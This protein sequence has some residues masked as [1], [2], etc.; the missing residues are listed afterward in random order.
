M[1]TDAEFV[2]RDRNAARIVAIEQEARSAAATWQRRDDHEAHPA[3]LPDSLLYDPLSGDGDFRCL[4]LADRVERVGENGR[5]RGFGEGY[6]AG[7]SAADREIAALKEGLT[8]LLDV[9]EG[10]ITGNAVDRARALLK[11]PSPVEAG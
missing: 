3:G 1:S 11:D 8:D 6:Q 7:R 2:R 9:C 5:S 10:T 4:R